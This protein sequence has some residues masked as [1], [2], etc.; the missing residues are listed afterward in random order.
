MYVATGG[1]NVKWGTDFKWGGNHWPT[2]WRRPWGGEQAEKARYITEND[3]R[4]LFQFVSTWMRCPSPRCFNIP[5]FLLKT[6]MIFFHFKLLQEKFEGLKGGSF[7]VGHWR[8][9][10]L[11]RH[12]ITECILGV[13]ISAR[14]GDAGDTVASPTLKNW[15]LFGQRFSKF[16]QSLQLHSHASDVVSIFLTKAK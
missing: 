3:K 2:S 13:S 10:A 6:S 12:W 4:D 16:G 14:R 5:I 9:L 1:P 11:R 8:H 15:P 7:M